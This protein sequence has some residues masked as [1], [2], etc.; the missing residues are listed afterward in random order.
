MKA[1][2]ELVDDNDFAVFYHVL[3]VLAIWRVGL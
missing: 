1:S 2:N 3:D